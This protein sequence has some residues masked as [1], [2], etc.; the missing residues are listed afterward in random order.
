[1]RI[2]LTGFPPILKDNDAFYFMQLQ[3]IINSTDEY[4]HV[5]A[6]NKLSG[7][8]VRIATSTPQ[9]SQHVLKAIKDFHYMLHLRVEFS[10]SIRT[11]STIEYQIYFGDVEKN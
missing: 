2:K 3:G 7:V 4:A 9:Y 1:M 5:E 11:T 8:S 10:K 6:T